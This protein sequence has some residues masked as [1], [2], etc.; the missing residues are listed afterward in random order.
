MMDTSIIQERIGQLC[1]Q[2]KLPTVAAEATPRHRCPPC[3][4][5]WNPRPPRASTGSFQA[6]GRQDLG[7][8]RAQ[9]C[10]PGAQADWTTW[11]R[12]IS[13]RGVN[14]PGLRHRQDSGSPPGGA[15][16]S[17]PSLLPGLPP[18]AGTPRRQRDLDLPR[19]LRKLDN[20][21]PAPRRPGHLPQGAEESG[22]LPLIAERSIGWATQTWSS[23][24]TLRQ[25]H[26]RR[27]H[28]SSGPSF[29]H[30]RVRRPQL[31]HRA[32]LGHPTR[33]EN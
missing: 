10:P 18:G 3:W 11:P 29:R 7:D 22:P 2:F 31:P 5:C 4:K 19:R 17:V 26:G 28:R 6:A 30:S 25:P 12:V 14:G 24:R 9:P 1:G 16:H 15:G 33:P 23:R 21:L 13:G 20:R 8:L 32:A 27:G